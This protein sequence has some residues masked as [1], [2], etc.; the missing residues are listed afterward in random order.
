MQN[1]ARELVSPPI[2][3]Q[4]SERRAAPRFTSVIRAAKLVSAQGEF[5]CIVR[6]VSSSGISLRTF[7]QL[8]IGAQMALELQNGELYELT[9]V[10]EEGRE[11]SFTFNHAVEV[12]N[13]IRESWEFPKRALRLNIAIPLT[14]ST[15][16][17]EEVAIT[18]NL[19]QQGARI[20]CDAMLAI[21]ETIKLDGGHLPEIKA[22]VRWRRDSLYGLVFENTFSLGE[23]AL[24]AAGLQS[25]SLLR[26][27][28][29]MVQA[30]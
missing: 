5:V 1:V 8:P 29:G 18:H 7:H 2:P 17:L 10:R 6:D 25:P 14:V 12:Q 20:E 23:F 11:A 15:P 3:P 22:K 9:L 19:S 16:S 28:K 13:L 24:L 21:D 27:Q 4:P 26:C 30:A